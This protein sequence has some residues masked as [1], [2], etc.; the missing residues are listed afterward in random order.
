MI[1]AVS[2]GFGVGADGRANHQNRL[3]VAD[4]FDDP[5]GHRLRRAAVV[6]GAD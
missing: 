5:L 3:L 4:K 2:G 6:L 1:G